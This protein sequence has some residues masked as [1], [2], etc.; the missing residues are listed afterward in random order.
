MDRKIAELDAEIAQLLGSRRD[1]GGPA[2]DGQAAARSRLHLEILS[3]QL[4]TRTRLV[5]WQHAWQGL[6]L[7]RRLQP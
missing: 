3:S 1:A 4:K 2:G 5:A 6:E 7:A